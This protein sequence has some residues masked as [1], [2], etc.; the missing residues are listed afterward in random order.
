MEVSSRKR[1]G[2]NHEN[3]KIEENLLYLFCVYNERVPHG[4]RFI[5]CFFALFYQQGKNEQKKSS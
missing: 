5:V 4:I 3:D 2:K 1:S